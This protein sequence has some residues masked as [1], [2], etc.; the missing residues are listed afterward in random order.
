MTHKGPTI[1]DIQH[2]AITVGLTDSVSDHVIV[3]RALVRM[4][5]RSTLHHFRANCANGTVRHILTGVALEVP[6]GVFILS[7]EQG[8]EAI[9]SKIAQVFNA[10]P[11]QIAF[12]HHSIED[13]PQAISSAAEDKI[14][15]LLIALQTVKD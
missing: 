15:Q 2:G 3:H 14:S 10:Q 12:S 4:G 6:S 8:W 9:R 13:H 7:G 1:A 5:V 11:K